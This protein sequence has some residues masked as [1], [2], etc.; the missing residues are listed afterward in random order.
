PTFTLYAASDHGLVRS[1]DGGCAWRPSPS[2]LGNAYVPDVFPDPQVPGRVLSLATISTDAQYENGIY[3]SNDSAATVGPSIYSDPEGG[4][5][6]GIEIAAGDSQILVAT[7][8]R[9]APTRP[10]LLRSNDGGAHWTV[11]DLTPTLGA[12][13]VRLAGIDVADPTKVYLR[14]IDPT[15]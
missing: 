9:L 10:A 3:V 13:T 8:A 2:D 1:I 15:G 4:V 7:M 12:K 5:L 6:S 11:L 14:V